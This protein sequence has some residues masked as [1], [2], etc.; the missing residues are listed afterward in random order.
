MLSHQ[1]KQQIPSAIF[2]SEDL[3]QKFQKF[4]RNDFQAASCEWAAWIYV[5]PTEKG[6]RGL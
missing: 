6:L 1:G 3:G 5:H 4:F 2:S